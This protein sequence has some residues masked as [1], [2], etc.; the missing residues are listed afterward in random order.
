MQVRLS[1]ASGS[2]PGVP[3]SSLFSFLRAK[4]SLAGAV[5]ADFDTAYVNRYADSRF[6]NGSNVDAGSVAAA[7]GVAAQ[8]L[9]QL[10]TGSGAPQL[11]VDL[12]ASPVLSMPRITRCSAFA[13]WMYLSNHKS[14]PAGSIPP[15]PGP[16]TQCEVAAAGTMML[17]ARQPFAT[18]NY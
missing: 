9:H 15:L 16:H 13:G 1:R 14:T 7:A 4:P 6:D 12:R 2:N 10:A 11:Q 18:V 3:P 8:A 17:C 5:L